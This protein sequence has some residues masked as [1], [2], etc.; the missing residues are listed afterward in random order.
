MHVY[1]KYFKVLAKLLVYR[2]ATSAIFSRK[3][4]SINRCTHAL[5]TVRWCAH[6]C[7]NVLFVW[8]SC[9][10]TCNDGQPLTGRS[11]TAREIFLPN[12]WDTKATVTL[13]YNLQLSIIEFQQDMI[14]H[15]NIYYIKSYFVYYGSLFWICYRKLLK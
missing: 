4:F 9:I 8:L 6:N 11:T 15:P 2:S 12:W 10:N 13:K 1:T 14:F 5:V 3:M 7:V